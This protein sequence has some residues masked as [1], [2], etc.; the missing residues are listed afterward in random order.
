MPK[1]AS[2][3]DTEFERL[4]LSRVA[5]QE[6]EAKHKQQVIDAPLYGISDNE[7]VRLLK[8]SYAELIITPVKLRALR[9]RW[10][11]EAHMP[12][13]V[14]VAHDQTDTSNNEAGGLA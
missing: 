7:M 10:T 14:Q 4:R 6:L 8:R 13:T 2:N 5:E 3:F 1:T 9:A 12:P 11:H